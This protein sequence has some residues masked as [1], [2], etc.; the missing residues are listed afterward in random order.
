MG[1]RRQPPHVSSTSVAEIL[2]TNI[3]DSDKDRCRVGPNATVIH[4][5]AVK[6]KIRP[7][8]DISFC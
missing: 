7:E 3:R 1:K 5:F 8:E 6:G 4:F 2:K